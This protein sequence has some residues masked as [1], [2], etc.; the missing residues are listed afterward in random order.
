MLTRLRQVVLHPGLIPTNY[1]EHMRQSL[2]EDNQD[3]PGTLIRVTAELKKRLQA[4]L[5]QEIED[6][7]VRPL[8]VL[9]LPRLLTSPKGVSNLL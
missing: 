4:I 3:K 7:E 2:N 5:A 6:S 9:L 1:V 8:D